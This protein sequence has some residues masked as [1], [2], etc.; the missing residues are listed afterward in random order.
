MNIMMFC[1]NPVDGGTAKVFYELVTSF[2]ENNSNDDR[3]YAGVNV[4]NPVA[5][6]NKIDFLE[7][8]EVY[9]EEE[10]CKNL[11]QGNIFSRAIKKSIRM[12]KYRPIKENNIKIMKEYL[13]RNKIDCI[14]IHNGGYV[15]D[16][17]CNQMLQ[18]AYECKEHT[19]CRIYVLHN[20][21]EKNFFAKLRFKSYDK[22]ICREATELVT[23][24]N[25]TK[26][27]ILS[28]SYINKEIKVIYNGLPESNSLTE[29][30]K[31][32]KI[33]L[34]AG[35]RNILMLGNFQQNKGQLKF[36]E[37]AN[38]IKLRNPNV[39]FTFIGNVYDQEYFMKCCEQLKK[40]NLQNS[41]T[42]LHGIN[43]ASEYMNL[44][45]AVAVPSMYDESFGLIS[46]EAMSKGVP[47]VAFAC[48]G[49]PE[50]LVDGRDGYIVSVG[51]CKGMADRLLEIISDE[52]KR[53]KM[54]QNGRDDYIQKFSVN[55]M[56][57]NYY[58]II[59]KYKKYCS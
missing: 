38:I 26:N 8:L 1:S 50:V 59:E 32:N 6:Y 27:R 43:N 16:D 40:Y 42:I 29:N 36:I 9:S 48:G 28:N 46:V 41:S 5:I 33:C 10:V 20:D 14:I 17:L 52:E 49:I 24:S 54:G 34:N 53:K 56:K 58:E 55:A 23:V 4:N 37:A 12:I 31:E 39:Y 3:I 35:H 15:G 51:D 47:V 11:Y 21:F 44:F 57:E 19:I 22:K 2:K 7:R 18:A 45:D 30:Q 13:S 25:Y